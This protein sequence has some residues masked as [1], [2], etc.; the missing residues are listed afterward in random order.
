MNGYDWKENLPKDQPESAGALSA[1]E[2][3]ETGRHKIKR[4]FGDH[5]SAIFVIVLL[6]LQVLL[7]FVTAGVRNPLT[8][9]YILNTTLSVSSTLFGWYMFLPTGRRERAAMP[10]YRAVVEKWQ[11]ISRKIMEQG[12]LSAFRR[13]CTTYARDE[14]E[15]I[16]QSRLLVLENAG[17]SRETFVTKYR[18]MPRRH[19]LSARRRGELTREQYRLVLFCRKPVR[20]QPISPNFVLA[21]DERGRVADAVRPDFYERR[22]MITKPFLCLL[23]VVLISFF[24]PTTRENVNVLD[25]V[26]NIVIR[27]FCV[28]MSSFSGFV[29]GAR[30]AGFRMNN[31]SGRLIFMNE[32]FETQKQ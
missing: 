13:F 31:I 28:C 19:L 20:E 26:V 18:D 16:K 9:D 1:A 29:T 22:V 23:W 25:V 27:I 15:R 4:A 21:G 11:N 12:Y 14:A 10:D 24:F 32:F 3:V 30:A 8:P 7:P 2:R 5:M 17:V 6:L